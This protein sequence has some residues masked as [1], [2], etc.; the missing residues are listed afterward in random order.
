MTVRGHHTRTLRVHREFR[1]DLD[2]VKPVPA[3]EPGRALRIAGQSPVN[4][5]FRWPGSGHDEARRYP[6]PGPE[7]VVSSQ[8][9]CSPLRVVSWEAQPLRLRTASSVPA[10]R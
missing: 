3:R 5:L 10:T 4:D 9:W 1:H 6:H 8:S 2:A 7:P